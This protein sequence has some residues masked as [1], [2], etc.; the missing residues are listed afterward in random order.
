[1]NEGLSSYFQQVL[2]GHGRCLRSQL[3]GRTCLSL[4]EF[5]VLIAGGLAPE[6]D[7]HD[8]CGPSWSSAKVDAFAQKQRLCAD[9]AAAAE[10]LLGYRHD[11]WASHPSSGTLQVDEALS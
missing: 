9:F 10:F 5:D 4:S 2:A 3:P 11:D 6:P 8:I 7:C 1:M